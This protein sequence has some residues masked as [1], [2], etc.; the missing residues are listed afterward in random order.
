MSVRKLFNNAVSNIEF[1]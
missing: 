1:V